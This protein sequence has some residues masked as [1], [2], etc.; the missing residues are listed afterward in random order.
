MSTRYAGSLPSS[1]L[2]CYTELAVLFFL[3]SSSSSRSQFK[4]FGIDVDISEVFTCG[5]A[6]A[7][8]IK[9]VVLPGIKDESPRGIYMIGQKA[10]EEEFAE[11]GLT[12]KGGTVRRSCQRESL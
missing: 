7:S 2:S 6:T 11:E 10:L 9:E 4:G 12:W 5:S 3:P 1:A 8:Y